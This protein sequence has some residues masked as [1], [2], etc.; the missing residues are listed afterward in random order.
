MRISFD[1]VEGL[2]GE[3]LVLFVSKKGEKA[4][5]EAKASIKVLRS[6]KYIHAASN[7]RFRYAAP[8]RA[9]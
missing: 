2:E 3:K 6:V 1:E 5:A 7:D 4:K 9:H 8:L